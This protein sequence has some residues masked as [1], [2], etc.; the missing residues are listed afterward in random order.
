MKTAIAQALLQY[1]KRKAKHILRWIT[2]KKGLLMLTAFSTE[3]CSYKVGQ[4]SCLYKE[5]HGPGS[6][7]YWQ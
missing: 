3:Y 7:D 5:D 4:I 1:S 6:T 2:E